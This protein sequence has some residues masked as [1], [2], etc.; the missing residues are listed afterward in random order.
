MSNVN[1]KSIIDS[2]FPCHVLTGFYWYF[3]DCIQCVHVNHL[4]WLAFLLFPLM[5]WLHPHC[6]ALPT[7][8]VWPTHISFTSII[9]PTPT[10][11]FFSCGQFLLLI[12]ILHQLHYVATLN[13]SQYPLLC[14]LHVKKIQF[15]SLRNVRYF[16]TP[17][18]HATNIKLP[19]I[20]RMDSLP[21]P[22]PSLTR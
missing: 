6:T 2:P 22:R 11:Y 1:A 21:S 20:Y 8:K 12:F 7:F 15:P 10:I 16:P 4:V 3:H 17:P 13:H 14:F 18:G 5:S 19:N 9:L